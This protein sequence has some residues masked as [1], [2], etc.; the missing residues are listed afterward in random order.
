[1]TTRTLK[2]T[3]FF[4][5]LRRLRRI[6]F[7]KYLP[8]SIVVITVAI[9]LGLVVKLL[10][11]PSRTSST[12][13]V[14]ASDSRISI[15]GARASSQLNQEF[16]FPLN[17]SA[18]SKLTDIKFILESAELRDEIIVKGKRATAVQ[19]RTFLILNLKISSAY[20]RALNINTQDYFRLTM[21]DK[22][23]QLLAPD[24]HNDPVVVQPISTKLA[25]LGF[26][27]NDTDKNLTL[28]VG[29][30]AGEKTQIDLNLQ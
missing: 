2:L 5:S 23:D 8:Q 10:T 27:V 9:T 7:K 12:S 13:S 21:N 6:P 25:R 4:S 16:S 14:P 28:W 29:E 11:R 26:P 22:P 3:E 17:S 19:G 15:L 24:I 1:M 20:S 30:V 18:G